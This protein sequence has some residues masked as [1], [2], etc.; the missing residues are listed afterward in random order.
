MPPVEKQLRDA[1][2]QKKPRQAGLFLLTVCSLTDFRYVGC[3]RSFLSLHDFEFHFVPFGERLEA[4]PTDG[5]EM[6]ENV[7]AS[8]SRNEAKSLGVIEP[9]YR[10]S[11]PC[12]L[13]IPLDFENVQTIRRSQR[14]ASFVQR[15]VYAAPA[16]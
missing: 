8:L 1:R 2:A 5:A 16:T 10:T 6:D 13:T 14:K 11:Y 15:I 9:L 4:G 3:L 12:H 7:R